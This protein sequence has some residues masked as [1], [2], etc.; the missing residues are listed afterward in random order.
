MEEKELNLLVEKILKA[1]GEKID[2]QLKEKFAEVVKGMVTQ[3][4]F[5]ANKE[6]LEQLGETLKTINI[7]ELS[8]KSEEALAELKKDIQTQID[9]FG[10]I[11]KK[12]N[13]EGKSIPKTTYDVF[14]EVTESPE[15]KDFASGKTK[16]MPQ[17][18]LKDITV[19][20][21]LTAEVVTPIRLTQEVAFIP[22][23]EFD[24]RSAISTGTSDSDII[25][26]VQELT[27]TDNIGFLTEV[28]ASA[29]SDATFEQVKFDSVRVGTHID[30]SKKSLRNLSFLISYLSLR[31]GGLMAEAITDSVIN[32]D[33]TGNAFD[34]LINNATTFTAGTLA[35][36]VTDANTADTI[37]AALCRFNEGTNM[38]ANIIFMNPKDVYLMNVTKDTT[39]DY[40][41]SEVMVSRDADGTVR[42]N[43]VPIVQTYHIAADTYLLGTNDASTVQY[44][45]TAVVSLE[46]SEEHADNWIEAK[47]TFRIEEEAILAILKDFAWLTGT[48]STDKTAITVP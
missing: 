35:L 41:E 5:E 28:A 7:E 22:P 23:K 2:E 39:S 8:K 26:H 1:S 4:A 12:F 32:G 9:E 37:A 15:F 16:S 43:G 30:V 6:T 14:K 44:L 19:S 18:Q 48:I 24:I 20:G 11:M 46:A 25:D 17:I 21:S 13:Q 38:M 33:G 10:V 36:S 29:E 40:V 27:F 47:V 3:E 31:F 45:T 42:I 34:G